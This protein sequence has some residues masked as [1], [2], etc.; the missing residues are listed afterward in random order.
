MSPGGFQQAQRADHIGLDE[1]FGPV[2][3]AVHMRLGG[4]V[5][6]G[7]GLVLGQQLG[8]Q[9]KVADIALH[10]SVA[11]IALQRGQVFKVARVGEFVEVDDGLVLQG[12]GGRE[13]VQHKVGANETR[14]AG[15]QNH[16]SSP[17]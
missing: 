12:V 1:V 2:D 14:A 8:N 4:K 15:D 16:E 13:P 9:I 5:D 7:A 17:E 10:K 6:D 3:G 11:G